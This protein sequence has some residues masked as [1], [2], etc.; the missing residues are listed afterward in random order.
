[1]TTNRGV[2]P[3]DVHGKCF[4]KLNQVAIADECSIVHEKSVST[5]LELIVGLFI[6]IFYI[7]A[8]GGCS[9]LSIMAVYKDMHPVRK[10][11]HG[12]LVY[13]EPTYN[14]YES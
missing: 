10:N 9:L 5:C 2:L 7:I 13:V 4:E 12:L 8:L 11:E 14:R 3:D 1:M 6:C